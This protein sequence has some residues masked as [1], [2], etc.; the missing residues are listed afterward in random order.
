MADEGAPFRHPI[1]WRNPDFY[2][3]AALE[4]ETRRVFDICHSCRRCFNLC[5]SFP[6]LFDLIDESE[7]G[8]LDSVDSSGFGAVADACTLC[9]MC[10]MTMCPYTPP[11]EWNVDFPHLMLRHRAAGRRAGRRH[12]GAS[13]QL[14]ETDRNGRLARTLAP[15]MNWGSARGNRLTRPLMEAVAGVHREAPLPR[16]HRRT[17]LDRAA[18]RPLAVN[19]QAP[20][21]GRKAVIYA[22]CFANYNQPEI[23]AAARA[24]LARNG[25]ETAVVY[26]RCCGMPQLEEGDIERVADSARHTA[27]ALG[28]WIER[29]YDVI[30]LVASCALMLKLEWPLI[31]PDDP[32]VERLSAHSSD[33]CEYVVGIAREEGL[34]PGLGPLDGAVTLHLPCHERAQNIG[35]KSA[36]MLALVP[37]TE[38]TLIERCS[39]HGGSI[40]VTRGFHETALKVGRPTARRA[41]EAANPYLA[42]ECPLAGA[43]IVNGIARQAAKDGAAV[44]DAATGAP[45]AG[46]PTAGRAHHPI[47]LLARAYGLA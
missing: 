12:T 29:G 5:D 17:M 22:T 44:D 41:R 10:F 8:E 20:A 18:K 2:D 42:S 26:P 47:E 40:G 21:F 37:D 46:A 11:H 45:A 30:A 7:T 3:S 32:A 4:R 27:A 38:V 23:G 36:D 25:V 13:R 33:I 43:H 28:E 14:A 9:D 6:R 15:V 1:D 16:Y 24:V 39:G 34:A 31:L 19:R 35:R